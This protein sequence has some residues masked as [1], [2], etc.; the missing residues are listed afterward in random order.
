VLHEANRTSFHSQA[1][2]LPLGSLC[3]SLIMETCPRSSPRTDMEFALF[4]SFL[5]MGFAPPGYAPWDADRKCLGKEFTTPPTPDSIDL[6]WAIGVD[7][8]IRNGH[9]RNGEALRR[10]TMIAPGL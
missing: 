4:R 10:A 8:L 9:A 6:R 1:A 2:H 5:N 3:G 7:E